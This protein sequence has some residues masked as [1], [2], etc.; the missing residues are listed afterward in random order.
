MTDYSKLTDEQLLALYKPKAAPAK[1]GGGGLTEPDKN[2]INKAWEAAKAAGAVAR[3]ANRFVELNEKQPTGGF[4]GLNLPLDLGGV[5]D[6]AGMIDPEIASMNALSNRMAPN[7]RQAGDPST[8]E[9]A[10]Y[11]RSAPN[12]DIP[13]PANRE[14]AMQLGADAGKSAARAAFIDRW[15]AQRGSLGGAEQAFEQ[16]WS[17]YRGAGK[18]GSERGPE[19]QLTSGNGYK[20]R[21][22]R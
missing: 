5:S 20:I 3:D 15:G 11:R 7:F 18:R 6:V 17:G 19:A 8:K 9:I 10:M 2:R 21:A 12:V 4:L 16:W 22:V 13:G 14:I 1:R